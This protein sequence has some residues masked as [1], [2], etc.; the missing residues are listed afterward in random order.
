M[1]FRSECQLVNIIEVSGNLNFTAQAIEVKKA[2]KKYN[3]RVIC[4]DTNGLGIGLHDELLKVNVDP[5]TGEEYPSWNT[6]NTDVV[7]EQEGA[8]RCIYDLKPQSS[9]TQIIT[10]FIDFVDSGKLRLLIQK[11]KSE[12]SLEDLE[13]RRGNVLPFLLTD[14]LIEE[15]TN[16][17]L[18]VQPGG[19]LSIK[20]ISKKY[21]KDK[22]SALQY[23]LW[24]IKTFEE[25]VA[26]AEEDIGA[27]LA[28]LMW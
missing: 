25:S 20:Q 16:L 27:L 12:Y 28:C 2:K 13:N 14:N 3:A 11:A 19:K 26:K 24:Y 9:N 17:K 21:D 7:P 10:S 15:I 4:I 22:F 8:E 5:T 1:L 6:L 23:V 18:E